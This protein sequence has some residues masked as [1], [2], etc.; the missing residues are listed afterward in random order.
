[1]WAEA[2][3]H[4]LGEATEPVS[5]K[6]YWNTAMSFGFHIVSGCFRDMMGELDICDGDSRTCKA[7]NPYSPALYR[8]SLLTPP[9]GKASWEASLQP[10]AAG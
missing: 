2:H 10:G 5:C 4:S 1:M 6:F 8:E 7:E 3:S 9:P